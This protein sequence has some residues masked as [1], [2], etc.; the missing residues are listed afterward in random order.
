MTLYARVVDNIAVEL[1]TPQEGYTI[2][3]SFH[4]IVRA[5]FF[6]VPDGTVV[7]SVWD[8]AKWVPPEEPNE[9]EEEQN[10]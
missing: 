4:P 3:E 7:N 10:V 1:F 5:M 9:P 8:G 6:E 2:D